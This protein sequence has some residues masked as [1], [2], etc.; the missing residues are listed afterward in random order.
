[1]TD[2]TLYEY[3]SI[4]E[5]V[6]G[7]TLQVEAMKMFHSEKVSNPERSCDRVHYGLAGFDDDTFYP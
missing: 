1:M 2:L 4:P 3:D 7:Q 5:E 6:L